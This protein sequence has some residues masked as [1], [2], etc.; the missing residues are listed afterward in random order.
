MKKIRLDEEEEGVPSTALREVAVLM[1]LNQ[2]TKPGA[3]CIVK[4][5]DVIHSDARLI[6]V[7]EFL[8]LDLKRYMDAASVAADQAYTVQEASRRTG[9][10]IDAA[11]EVKQRTRPRRGLP[12]E[13]V[14]VRDCSGPNHTRARWRCEDE[15]LTLLSL[16]ARRNCCCSCCWA[17]RTCTRTGSCTATSSRKTCSSTARAI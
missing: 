1:E 2:S 10:M 9:A 14:S 17:C 4:L 11:T 5:L 13:L 6:L 16:L 7:F 8:D 12:S 3:E 15:L